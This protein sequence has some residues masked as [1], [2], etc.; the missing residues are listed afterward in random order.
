MRRGFAADMNDSREY[1][2]TFL[3]SIAAALPPSAGTHY[4]LVLA[5]DARGDAQLCLA[6]SSTNIGIYL[7]PGDL[8]KPV[9]QLVDECVVL[10]ARGATEAVQN[11]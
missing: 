9:G 10:F 7:D 3:R 6:M 4:E 8:E 5:T 2:M 1:L 11:G